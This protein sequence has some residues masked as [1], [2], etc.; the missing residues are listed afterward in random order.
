MRLCTWSWLSRNV[1][2]QNGLS[3]EPK[4]L[5]CGVRQIFVSVTLLNEMLSYVCLFPL[6]P[7]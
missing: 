2:G 4:T 3:G 5:P 7:F 1:G 6:L